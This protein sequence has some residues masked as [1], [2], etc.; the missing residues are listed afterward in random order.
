V[1]VKLSEKH[2]RNYTQD[3]L[4]AMARREILKIPGIIF[5]ITEAGSLHAGAPINMNLKGDDLQVLKQLSETLKEKIARVP[6][7]VDVSS[8]LDQDKSE[9]RLRIDRARAVNVGVSTAQVVST[10]GPLIGGMVAT[11]YED[12]DGDSYD[13]RVR[14]PEFYRRDPMQLRRLTLLATGPAGTRA[15]V[16]LGDI[17]QTT[18]DLSPAKIQRLDLQRQVTLSASNAGIPLGDAINAIRERVEEVGLPP[19]YKISWSGEA[20]DMAET[21]RYIFEALILAVILIY[22]ILAA[23][24]ESFVAPLSIMISLPLSLVGVVSMLYLTGDTLNIMSLIGLIMLM[25]LVT[26]NAILLIDYTQV[27]RNRGL[28]R[29]SA[30]IEA[31]RTRLRPIIMTTMAMIFG[32]LPLALALGPGAEMRAPMARA[33]IGGLITSTLLT[34]VMV[35]VV[36]TLLEDATAFVLRGRVRRKACTPDELEAAEKALGFNK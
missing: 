29:K 20:E 17:S 23:Q 31:G 6:G 10:L 26:K 3:E 33:V 30:L 28:D 14:L 12:R 25:G 36:Y 35:P 1:Y 24:F 22:L 7:V 21:F 34:L 15:L 4:E 18:L 9:V 13:V 27:L 2:E 32:M 8:S 19:G 16:P 11:T 5:S